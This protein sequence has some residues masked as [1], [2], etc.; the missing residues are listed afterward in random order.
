MKK[1]AFAAVAILMLTSC[2]P[3]PEL[4]YPNGKNRVPVNA[5]R[6]AP[7]KALA[8]NNAGQRIKI[9]QQEILDVQHMGFLPRGGVDYSASVVAA[10]DQLSQARLELAEA[11]QARNAIARQIGGNTG[12]KPGKPGLMGTVTAAASVKDA[13]G[14]T[15]KPSSGPEPEKTLEASSATK[16]AKTNPGPESRK[17]AVFFNFGSRVLTPTGEV[18]VAALAIDAR[19][20][21][22]IEIVGRADNVGQFKHNEILAKARAESVRKALLS[23]GV[24]IKDLVVRS[25]VADVDVSHDV[26]LKGHMPANVAERSRRADVLMALRG[27]NEQKEISENSKAPV[28]AN[29]VASN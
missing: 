5:N 15:A 24:K 17:Y 3:L 29:M 1:T 9:N 20:S 8:A 18:A 19:N 22:A 23:H 2:A 13:V 12:G 4:K 26:K 16:S 6:T 28:L 10:T 7:P 27:V 21:E 14:V 25:E 11:E